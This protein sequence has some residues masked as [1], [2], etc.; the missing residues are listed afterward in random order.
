METAVE[1]S[2]RKK[3][4]DYQINYIMNIMTDCIGNPDL[5]FK[6]IQL[7]LLKYSKTKLKRCE[8]INVMCNKFASVV[9]GAMKCNIQSFPFFF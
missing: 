2:L 4:S 8:K 6:V 9:L 1:M 3:K 5:L 7:F